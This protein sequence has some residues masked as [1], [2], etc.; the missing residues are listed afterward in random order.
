MY[1]GGV[2]GSGT[3]SGAGGVSR[4]GSLIS[5]GGLRGGWS[6]SPGGSTGIFFSRS[7]I[8]L[9]L[10][11]ILPLLYRRSGDELRCFS[12]IRSWIYIGVPRVRDENRNG[13]LFTMRG[14]QNSYLVY[15]SSHANC[16]ESCK[17]AD[18][19]VLVL[20]DCASA[21]VSRY[22]L[23]LEKIAEHGFDFQMLS[24]RTS[25]Q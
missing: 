3:I 10:P 11:L 12:S 1:S 7:G 9:G 21:L 14:R 24:V 13:D 18:F 17:K 23:F 4:F 19:L 6:L 15:C 2:S 16:V 5:G 20:S 25:H 22:T 8:K